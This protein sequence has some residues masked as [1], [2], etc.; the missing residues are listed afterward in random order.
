M[1]VDVL[2]S[3]AGP[4]GLSLALALAR[5]GARVAVWEKLP[6]LSREARAST[7]HPPTLEFF[8]DI[9]VAAEVVA[10]GLIIEHL[11]FWERSSREL[12]ADFPY[13]LIA[14]DTPFPFRLQCPQSTVTRIIL[15]R[16]ETL[17]CAQVSFNHSFSRFTETPEGVTAYAQT[18]AGE[19]SIRCRYVVGCDGA[20]SQVRESLGLGF[21]GLTYEDRFLLI[22]SDIQ[23]QQLF[24]SMG[25]VAYIFDPQE[26]VIVMTLPDAVRVAFRL[27][28]EED[29]EFAKREENARRRISGFLES[30]LDYR[31]KAIST[32]HIHQRVTERFRV[33]PAILAGDAAHINNPTGGMGMNSGIHDARD[34]AQALFAALNGA[35]ET[36]LDEYAANRKGVAVKMVQEV[37]DRNYKNLTETDEAARRERNRELREAANDPAKA[38]AYLL[39]TAMLGERIAL[40]AGNA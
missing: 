26:W 20:A 10:K 19:I 15:R 14:A 30:E 7:I 22:S 33:G 6:E 9:G 3:G 25:T 1:D 38:R 29:A 28:P 34:L 12:V 27:R 11:Q 36:V 23:L 18:P 31:V 16:L 17:D 35:D 21:E 13:S 5:R 8:D 32:Y 37:T 39:K 2:I 4:V 24:P 40:R